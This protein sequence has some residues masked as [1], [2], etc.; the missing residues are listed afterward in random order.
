MTTEKYD[1]QAE[2]WTET[3]YADAEAYLAHRADVVV[4]LGPRLAPGDV[5]LDLACGDGGLGEH[6]LARGLAYRGADASRA[7][8][9]AARRRL[10]DRATVERGDLDAYEPPG[11]VA[12]TTVFRAI[13]YAADREAFFRRVA[14]FTERKLVFDLNPRQFP[15]DAVTAELRRAGWDRVALRPFLF[16]QRHPLPAPVRPLLAAAERSGPLARLALRV[17]FTYLVAAFRGTN[18]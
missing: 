1:P 12:A 8:V 11:P 3:A 18:P 2:R 7:M 10:G 9:A 5:V 15:L 6:L 16:P 17:R 4:S 13:Y 14:G